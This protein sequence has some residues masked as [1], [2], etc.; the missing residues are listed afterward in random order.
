MTKSFNRRRWSHV[1]PRGE[2]EFKR[3]AGPNWKSLTAPAILPLGVDYFPTREALDFNFSHNLYTISLSEFQNNNYTSHLDLLGE[4][5]RQR[6]SQDFQLVDPGIVDPN[7][8]TFRREVVNRRVKSDVVRFFL[9]MGYRLQVL[10]Y[11]PSSD[12]VEVETY[13]SNQAKHDTRL[14]YEYYSFCQETQSY[15]KMVQSFTKYSS[16]YLWN[17]VDRIVCGNS[18][19]EMRVG[20]RFRRLMFGILPDN[21]EENPQSESEYLKSFERLMDYFNKLRDN[22]KD[23]PPLKVKIVSSQNRDTPK[24]EH[25]RTESTPGVEGSSMTRFYVQLRKGK[26]DIWEWMEVAIDATLDTRW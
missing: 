4:M 18:D 5:V 19:R 14:N 3:H 8:F 16:P 6:L 22:V 1:F 9:S 24:S 21:F 10:T 15:H 26:R 7:F 11:D 2:V 23:T 17:P 20:M 25:F 13:T 12:L